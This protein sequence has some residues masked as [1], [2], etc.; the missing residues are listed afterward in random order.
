MRPSCDRA[1]ALGAPVV[2]I[3]ARDLSSFAVDRAAQLELV[4]RVA[5]R[6]VIAE[7]GIY[8]RGRRPRPPSSQARAPCSSGRR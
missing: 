4:A 8:T 1:L 7:S 6:I 2:G 5:G 3:N